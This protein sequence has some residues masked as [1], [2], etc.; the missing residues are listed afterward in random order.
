MI[1]IIVTY[2][3]LSLFLC[4]G[5][6]M[7]IDKQEDKKVSPDKVEKKVEA[8]DKK[9]LQSTSSSTQSRDY[10]DFVDKNNN[11]IDDRAE[12]S[13]KKSPII[14]DSKSTKQTNKPDSSKPN[15]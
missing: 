11:G 12:K 9:E 4:G 7:A 8:Q 15:K 3:I 13:K 5:T 6:V 14:E 10:N 1:R 2:L